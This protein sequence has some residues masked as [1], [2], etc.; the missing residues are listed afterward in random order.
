[1]L[2]L[3]LHVCCAPCG[4]FLAERLGEKFRVAVYFYNPNIYP[5]AEYD[6]RRQEAEKFFRSEKIQFFVGPYDHENWLAPLAHLAD[7]P[8]RGQRC[9]KCY[10]WRLRATAAL[11]QEKKFDYFAASLAI[12]SHKD[13]PAVDQFGRELAR[14]FKVNFLAGDWKKKDGGRQALVFSR[15]HNFYRQR[16]CGCEFSL[17]PD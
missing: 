11:A 1:M 2:S 17:R 7:E 5:K 6:R 15:E 4:G 8:E 14:E 10:Y 3:L 12:S 9:L 13:A 16:Y